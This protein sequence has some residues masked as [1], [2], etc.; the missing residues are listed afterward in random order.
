MTR[1]GRELLRTLPV[2]LLLTAGFALSTAEPQ[3][4]G[5]SAALPTTVPYGC[6]DCHV[7]DSPVAGDAALNPF[8]VD[9]QNN[10]LVWDLALANMNSDGD[11]CANGVEIGDADGD[12]R[13]DGGVIEQSSNPGVDDCS[14]GALVNPQTWG[15]LKALFQQ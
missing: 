13:L 7:G 15:N 6:A 2:V 9:F 10:N 14:G 5:H 1:C 12:G 4:C 8:G 11:E 3:D